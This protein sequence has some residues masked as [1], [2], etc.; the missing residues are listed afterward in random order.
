MA[1][2]EIDARLF[3]AIPDLI[4]ALEASCETLEQLTSLDE[5]VVLLYRIDG[6]YWPVGEQYCT[7]HL[8]RVDGIGTVVDEVE[9]IE[10]EE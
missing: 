9:V 7:A 2:T 10:D 3:D 4:Q 6:G 1:L 5:G 8:K